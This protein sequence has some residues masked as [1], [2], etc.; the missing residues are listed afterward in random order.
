MNEFPIGKQIIDWLVKQLPEFVSKQVED[1]G[2]LRWAGAYQL[3]SSYGRGDMV[4][5][6]GA[7]WVCL[8]STSDKPSSVSSNW[9]YML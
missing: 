1:V 6:D 8:A 5:M 2:G 4:R 7:T 3:G 9:D